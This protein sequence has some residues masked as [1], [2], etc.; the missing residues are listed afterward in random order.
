MPASRRRALLRLAARQSEYLPAAG[1]DHRRAGWQ[2]A[3]A[4]FHAVELRAGAPDR[5]LVNLRAQY[6]GTRAVN[7]P[8]QTQV[9]GYQT[10][11]AGLLRAVPLR[12][13]GRPAIRRRDATQH[14]REQPLQRPA[15]DGRE[16]AG[17]GLQVQANYTWSHC[18]DTVSNGGFLSFSAG[19]FFRRCRAS[20]AAVRPLR[21]RCAPQLHGA[22][23]L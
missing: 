15:T 10:V 19:A 16:A 21:L 18:M 23:C 11:C 12:P 8:Y 14:R 22:V 3:R 7:Q 20:W 5:Q 1:G 4:V 2:A 17:H 13:A 6:V 9:N